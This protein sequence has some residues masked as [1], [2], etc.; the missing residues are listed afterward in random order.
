[1]KVPG[2]AE[3]LGEFSLVA[4][5]PF[6][7]A[8]RRLGLI[9]ADGLPAPRAGIVLAVFAW[10]LP[11]LLAA[12]Q[13]LLDGRYAGWGYFTDSTVYTRYLVG[14]WVM[15]ATERYAAGRIDLLTR[16]FREARLVP[17]GSLPTFAAAL[18]T[19]DRRSSSGVAEAAILAVALLVSGLSARYAA[20]I[21]GSS[22]EGA[23]VAGGVALSWAGSAAALVSNPLFLF[24]VLR[25]IW[26]FV[27]WTVLLYRISRLP[28]Q[29]TPLHPDRSAGLGFLALY[30]GIF[31]GFVFAL[32]CVVAS[33]FLKEL[34]LVR[35][36]PE[37][38]W[39]ALAGWLAISLVLFFGPLLVFLRPLY[40]ARERALLEYGRLANQHHLAFHRK[41]IGE[42]RGG[43]ALMGSSDPSSTSDLNASVQA[44]REMRVLPVDGP[45]LVQHLVAAGVPLLAVVAGQIPLGDLVKLIV[46]A[47]L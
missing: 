40:T 28:L 33:S 34:G 45:A 38:V 14:V 24:L 39:F 29:L 32:S 8:L 41:W 7:A 47:I 36:S 23:A 15:I 37:T 2:A 22:W 31:S 13:S 3:R 35:H 4:G 1:M 26:R 10:L 16:Q 21:A 12:A 43:E 46:G 30:P 27:V 19:A 9:A 11:A 20:A 18:A 42:A 6:H 44:V 25:W 17:D 5:G